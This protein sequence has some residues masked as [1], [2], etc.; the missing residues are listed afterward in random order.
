VNII[1][2][3]GRKAIASLVATVTFVAVLTGGAVASSATAHADVGN[4]RID[5]ITMEWPEEPGTQAQVRFQQMITAL[6]QEP[7]HRYHGIWETQQFDTGLLGVVIF[8]PQGPVELYFNPRNL[9]LQGFTNN[10]SQLFYFNDSDLP[11]RL[12]ERAGENPVRL[13]FSSTYTSLQGTAGR[14]RAGQSAS[15]YSVQDALTGLATT[16]PGMNPTPTAQ[17]L[18]LLIQYTAESARFPALFNHMRDVMGMYQGSQISDQEVEL[19]NDWDDLSTWA[20][21]I[22]RNPHGTPPTEVPDATAPNGR[23]TISSWRDLRGIMRV[24]LSTAVGKN[25]QP[26]VDPSDAVPRVVNIVPIPHSR[27]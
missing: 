8:T 11:Y 10:E 14:G 20:H 27:P 1:R 4:G 26:R 19:E 25:L 9:Y 21:N 16:R 2:R 7:S 18:M 12:R 24:V 5:W 3:I 6:R 23:R 13:G 15:F 17:R 22:I